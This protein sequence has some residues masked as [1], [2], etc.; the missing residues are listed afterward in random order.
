MSADL[1]AR[2]DKA[3]GNVLPAAL[4]DE[5][6]AALSQKEAA[7][8]EERSLTEHF[9]PFYLLSN[10]R[11]MS[12]R[13]LEREANWVLASRLFAVGST[14]ANR[15]CREAGIDPDALEVRKIAPPQAPEGGGL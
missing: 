15:I 5:I 7:P 2:L 12:G 13:R 3:V 11:S 10:C 1:I 8:S 6:A 4:R 14:T 9:T